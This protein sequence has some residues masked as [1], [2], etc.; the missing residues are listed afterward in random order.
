M[1]HVIDNIE[2]GKKKSAFSFY[3]SFHFLG[4]KVY[5]KLTVIWIIDLE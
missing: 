3:F 4:T 2:D 1:S 5:S